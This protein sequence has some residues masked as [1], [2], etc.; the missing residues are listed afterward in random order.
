MDYDLAIVGGGLSALSAIAHGLVAGNERSILLDYQEAPGGFLRHALPARGFEDAWALLQSLHF[1]P[2]MATHF[3]TT[4]VGL[5]PASSEGELHRLI[6]RNREGTFEIEAKRVLLACG[7]LETTRE[8][9]QIAGSRPVGV[10]TPVLA[11]QLLARGYLPGKQAVVYGNGRYTDATMQRL[12]QA[13]IQV[14]QIKP[15]EAGLL[16]IEGF[17]R[18]QQVTFCRDGQG[19]GQQ[20][21]AADMLVYS[22]GMMANTHWLKGSGILTASEGGILVD[23]AGEGRGYQTNI[24]G[25][26]AVGTVVRP[27]IDHIDSIAMGKEVATLLRGG[28]V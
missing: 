3:C 17:P 19:E 15:D 4:A 26:Y 7:G 20:S 1:P 12:K 8:H 9:A 16:S 24:S 10:M 18:L 6:A 25:I 28:T 5:L 21:V 27:S 2:G 22:V 11:H 13:G 23:G 14:T